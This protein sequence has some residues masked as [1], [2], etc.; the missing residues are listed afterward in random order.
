MFEGPLI[1]RLLFFEFVELTLNYM[2]KGTKFLDM[3]KPWLEKVGA[4]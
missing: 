1:H 3:A 2:S 4:L